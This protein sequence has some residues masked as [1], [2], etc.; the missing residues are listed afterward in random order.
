[1][2]APLPSLRQIQ[3][4]K[5]SS[6]TRKIVVFVHGIFSSHETF[7][8]L[9]ATFTADARFDEYDLA[10]YDYD[11]GHPIEKSASILRGILNARIPKDAEVTLVGH[12]MGGL[13]CRFAL[14]GGDLPCVKR[15]FMLGT[16]NFGAMTAAQVATI[17]QLAIGGA[18][19][20][21]PFFPR[22]AGLRDLTRVQT[23]YR[24]A[25]RHDEFDASRADAVP[26]VTIPGLFYHRDRRDTDPG[27]KG[28]GVLFAIGTLA[29]R[30]LAEVPLSGIEITR[31]H[32]GVVE[33]SSVNMMPS[34]PALS[35]EKTEVNDDP[36]RYGVS[37]C[38][39][40]PDSALDDNHMGI[41]ADQRVAEIV[42][43]LILADSIVDW[44]D[45]L[46]PKDRRRTRVFRPK[47]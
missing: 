19:K 17:W 45:T 40:V 11:W 27:T 30:V 37:Y 6:R 28:G 20:L 10:T 46:T 29:V 12:S 42:R 26:Y 31:P 16:P 1:M 9:L 44:H 34:D 2:N 3:N 7:A 47:V 39:V 25:S 38:H 13:V 15:I 43:E 5:T 41:H 21:M 4:G 35:S 36:E 22:K 24:D 18:G 32:D 8:Y 33:E 23:V 14:I